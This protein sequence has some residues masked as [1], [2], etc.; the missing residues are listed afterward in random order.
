MGKVFNFIKKYWVLI[1]I[2][3][4]LVLVI[5]DKFIIPDKKVSQ[6]VSTPKSNRVADYKS[7]QPGKSKLEEINSLLGYPIEQ[8]EKDGNIIAE[9]RSSSN[10]RNNLVT[11]QN[12]VATLIKE[13]VT[14]TDNKKSQDIIQEYGEAPFVLY[15][16]KPSS[17][18]N[19]YV[20]PT[21]GIAYLGHEDGTLLEVWYF[22]PIDIDSFISTW[23]KDYSKEK[24]TET[25][26]Y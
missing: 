20:Y 12:G 17:T 24:T 16:Q 7:I 19:L 6:T 4:M 5:I 26:K 15:D 3:L 8:S 11:V 14:A 25:L 10:Y 21:N 2:A 18:F 1:L 23:A 13:I 9:Y 22:Q